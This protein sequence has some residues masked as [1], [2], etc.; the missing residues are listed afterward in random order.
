MQFSDQVFGWHDHIVEEHL[1]EFII[2]RDRL[3]R[4]DPDAWAVQI[5]QQEADA[6]LPRLRLRIGAYEREHP[7]R[8][9]RPGGP[10]LLPS[11][12]EMIALQRCAGRKAGKVG[13]CARLGIAL[14]PDHSTRN[15]GRQMLRLLCVGPELHQDRADVIETLRRQLRCAN[16]RQLLRHDDLFV[17]GGTHAAMLPGPMRCDPAFAREL[18]IP[19]HQFHRRRACRAPPK[20][21]RKIGFQPCPYVHAEVGFSRRVTTEHGDEISY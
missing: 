7:V 15:D 14:R 3:D 18:V 10:D 17:E 12:H 1:A 16:A 13:A 6:G 2:A 8:M 20:R 11:H 9:M 4:P 19:G 21:N 5:K